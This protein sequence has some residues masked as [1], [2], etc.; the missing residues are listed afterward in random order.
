MKKLL[1]C[2]DSNFSRKRVI[3][4]IKAGDYEIIEAEDGQQA[5]DRIENENPDLVLLDLLMPNITGIEL[6]KM[7]KEKNKTVPVIVISADIQESTKAECLE[8]GAK[9]FLNKPPRKE[10]LLNTIEDITNN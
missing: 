10:V 5:M 7:L 6:L 9:E 3:D 8:L 1:V 2:D 4:M